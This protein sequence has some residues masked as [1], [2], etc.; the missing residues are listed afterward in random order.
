METRQKSLD[1]CNEINESGFWSKVQKTKGCWIWTASTIRGG[2]GQ[3]H[4]KRWPMKAHR[5]SWM[6]A[7]KQNVPNGMNVLHNC[8]TPAC[9]NPDHL[10]LGTA[11]D[12]WLDCVAKNRHMHGDNHWARTRPEL[13]PRGDN[14]VYRRHPELHC[15]GEKSATAKLTS[16][17]VKEIR[18]R[19][20]TDS[21]SCVKLGREYGVSKQNILSIIH[22]ETW[23]HV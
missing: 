2:Y 1:P 18:N 14:H 6:I 20:E 12:N 8:D 7:N 23:K 5:I 19:H 22:H 3:Y 13:V 10:F 11:M 21:V 9:V 16:D 15:R 17:L 4:V